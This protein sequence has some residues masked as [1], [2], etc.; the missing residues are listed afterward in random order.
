[1][2]YSPTLHQM[3]TTNRISAVGSVNAF[4]D[5]IIIVKQNGDPVRVAAFEN[6]R[7]QCLFFDLA[8]AG[9]RGPSSLTPSI[10][11]PKFAMRWPQ[12]FNFLRARGSIAS[13]VVGAGPAC[14]GIYR[15]GLNVFTNSPSVTS[16]NSIAISASLIVSSFQ[17][18]I[19]SH[20]VWIRGDLI[21]IYCTR[22]E[23]TT[24]RGGKLYIYGSWR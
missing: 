13:A 5:Q 16:L 17:S 19:A 15:N 3:Q 1:M 24:H 21:Q 20:E 18:P 11:L 6:R 23:A 12:N 9:D 4:S 22:S 14:F 7:E 2:L 10:S 8:T